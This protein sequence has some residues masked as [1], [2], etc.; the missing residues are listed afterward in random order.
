MS[1]WEGSVFCQL[2]YSTIEITRISA[3]VHLLRTHVSAASILKCFLLPQ[4]TP[5]TLLNELG[6]S[7]FVFVYVAGKTAC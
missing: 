1:K 4:H 7:F 6:N 5:L 2:Y 3:V